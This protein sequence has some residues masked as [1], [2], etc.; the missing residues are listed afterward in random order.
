MCVVN[1][2]K[3]LILE[4]LKE[5]R[6][7]NYQKEN[8]RCKNKTELHEVLDIKEVIVTLFDDAMLRKSL[9]V[10]TLT[11]TFEVDN[12]LRTLDKKIQ[13]LPH[14]STTKKLLE[15]PKWAEITQLAGRIYKLIII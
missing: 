5:L 4:C 15:S 13:L 11:F 8:A 10:M 7:M 14:L 2:N 6:D 12:M 1:V 3:L 9:E